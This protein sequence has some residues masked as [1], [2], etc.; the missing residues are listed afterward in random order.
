LITSFRELEKLDATYQEYSKKLA[1]TQEQYAKKA[2]YNNRVISE[3]KKLDELETPE[4]CSFYNIQRMSSSF[5]IIIEYE[6]PSNT[7]GTC[8]NE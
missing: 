8:C 5:H 1:E 3:T 7:Q 6:I 2:K 4:V